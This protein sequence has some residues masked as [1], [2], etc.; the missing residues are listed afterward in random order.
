MKAQPCGAGNTE[1]FRDADFRQAVEK[2]I[3]NRVHTYNI[4]Q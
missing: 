4:S 1:K 3:T 2:I